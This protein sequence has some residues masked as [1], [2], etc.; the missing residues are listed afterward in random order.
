MVGNLGQGDCLF[1]ALAAALRAKGIAPNI[2][3]KGVRD[4]LTARFRADGSPYATRFSNISPAETPFAWPQYCTSMMQPGTC[5]STVE[6]LAATEEWRVEIMFF[7]HSRLALHTPGTGWT[8]QDP[9][10]APSPIQALPVAPDRL[11]FSQQ[12]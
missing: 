10:L 7:F 1:H 5:G 2:T 6:L 3:A 9:T 12:S 8:Q 11:S 4:R